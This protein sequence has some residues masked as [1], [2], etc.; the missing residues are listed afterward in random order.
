M[1]AK[2]TISH[3]EEMQ[4]QFFQARKFDGEKYLPRAE[5]KLSSLE[6]GLLLLKEKINYLA[7][8]SLCAFIFFD[9]IY[10]FVYL[11]AYSHCVNQSYM[12]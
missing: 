5:N 1:L 2:K 12:L 8:C 4:G 7:E 11:A 10:L 9:L 6:S 3:G